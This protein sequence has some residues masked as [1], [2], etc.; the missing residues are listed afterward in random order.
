MR[1]GEADGQEEGLVLQ[2]FE[3]LNGARGRLIIAV[4]FTIAVEL[5]N[6]VGLHRVLAGASLLVDSRLAAKHPILCV[7]DAAVKNLAGSGGHITVR[8]EMLRQRDEV[9]M[10]VAEIGAVINDA[11]GI[12]LPAGEQACPRRIAEWKLAIRPLEANA[13]FGQ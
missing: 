3:K 4:G 9:G 6:A 10:R 2:L 12:R 11:R 1:L 8:L 7:V 13:A 5:H